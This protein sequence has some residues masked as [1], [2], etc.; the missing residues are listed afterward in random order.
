MKAQFTIEAGQYLVASTGNLCS[1]P[2]RDRV[3][4]FFAAHPVEA[5]DAALRH[6]LE[7]ISGC[8]EFRSLQEPKLQTWLASQPH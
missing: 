3:Q 1:A 2:D 5:S 4:Q 6:A 7:A 8:A